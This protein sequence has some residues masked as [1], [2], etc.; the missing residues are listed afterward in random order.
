MASHMLQPKV[1]PN[2][3]RNLQQKQNKQALYFNRGAKELQP[4]KDG[5]AVRDRPLPGHSRWLK[6]QMSSQEA[7]RSYQ[8]RTEDGRVYRR[9][10]SHLFKLPENFQVMPHEDIVESKVNAQT[11]PPPPNCQEAY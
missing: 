8:V 5:D 3:R 2:V 4:L 10:R 7:L 11:L 9:N 6:A 1:A